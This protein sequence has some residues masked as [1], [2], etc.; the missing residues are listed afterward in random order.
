M[1]EEQNVTRAAHRLHVAQPALSRTIRNLE[2]EVGIV[3]LKR[4]PG[5]VALT[6]AGQKFL[7]G[8]RRALAEAAGAIAR[9]RDAR[10]SEGGPLVVAVAVPELRE[11]ALESVLAA[12]RRVLPAVRVH[13]E[14]MGASTQWDALTRRVVDVG[15]AYAAAPIEHRRLAR[16]PLFEDVISGVVV[17]SRHRLA[18][19][20]TVLLHDL[21]RERLIMLDRVINPEVYDLIVRGFHMAGFVP[22]EFTTDDRLAE[23]AAPTMALVAA[24]HG[25]TMVPNSIRRAL[26]KSV[27]YIPLADF[28][29]PFTLEIM[30]RID[31]RSIRTRTFVRIARQKCAVLVR[32]SELVRGRPAARAHAAG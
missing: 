3:L 10:A 4:V 5:G 32:R 19:R 20:K 17:S 2:Q 6:P 30:H 22:R 15:V 18:R 8:A 13:V 1:A 14:A 21:G 29:V 7:P 26:P 23:N 31:D 25:W 27:R 24:G 9:A 16:I 12:Y 28:A 11:S